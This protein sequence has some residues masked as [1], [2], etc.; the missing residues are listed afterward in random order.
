MTRDMRIVNSHG[1]NWNHNWAGMGR[2]I[3]NPG[4]RPIC[5]SCGRFIDGMTNRMVW[6]MSVMCATCMQRELSK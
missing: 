5:W 2:E 3:N 6:G 1:E 4:A